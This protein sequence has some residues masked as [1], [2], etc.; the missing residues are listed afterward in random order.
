M[1]LNRPMNPPKPRS[2]YLLVFSFGLLLL[3]LTA[4]MALGMTRI[5]SF[6]SRLNE[7]T[8]SQSRN[9]GTVS[10]LFLSNGQRVSIIDRMF[11]AATPEERADVH[12]RYRRTIEIYNRAVTSL[13]E[14]PVSAASRAARDDAIRAAALARGVG[15]EIVQLLLKGQVAP[16]SELNLTQAVLTDGRLQETLYR[17][18]EANH[19]A[20]AQAV[21][22]ANQG[23]RNGF[24][25]IGAGGLFALLAGAVIAL[26]VI[27]VVAATEANLEH[28]KELAEVTLHSIVDGVITTDAS[29]RVDYLNPVA[30]R[31]LGWSTQDAHGKPL[32][33]VYRVID[34]R[35]GN[36]IDPLAG[37]ADAAAE[38]EPV[39]VRL[40]DRKGRE[41][42]IR[43]SHAP[44][45]GRDGTVHGMIVVFHDVSQVRAMA[46]QL[47]WQA[48]HDALTGLVNRREFER[49]LSE[50]IDTAK[51]Q[52][53]EHALLYLDL[54]N[55]K[56]VND[57][58]GHAAGDE[59]LRQLTSLMQTKMRGSDTLARLGGDEFGALLESCLTEQAVRVANAL[60]ETIREFRFVWQDK[61]FSVG[62]SIG[63][64]PLNAESRDANN[65]LTLADVCCYE[66]KNRGRDRV[67][68]YRP[69]DRDY[70][71]RHSDLQVVSQI[72]R[73]F[74]LG[75]FR[76][77]RQFIMPVNP[78]RGMP[79]HHE[80]LV[81]MLDRAGN[82]IPPT[83]FMP[84]AER[85]NLLT[86]IERWVVSTL[87]EYLHRQWLSGGI[88]RE[89][90][91]HGE[92]G[93]YSVNIS[94]ASINDKSFP[95]F[96]RNLLT[97]Y[98]LPHG[99]LCFEI[100]ETTAIS[101]LTKAAELMHELKGMGCRFALDDFGTGMSSFAY[102]KYLPVDY[103]KIAGMFIKDM[104][105]DPMDHAIVDSVNRIGHILGMQTVAES[106][107]DAA[108]LSRLKEMGVDY[109][110]G[111]FISEPEALGAES[112]HERAVLSA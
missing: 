69:Q 24:L 28:E 53:K 103:L 90:D 83:G 14:L 23:M 84:A 70:T 87:V 94:G 7:V 12:A 5:E 77:Y 31:Y 67:Q 25:L 54:D 38:D 78:A 52:G 89:T 58:C 93:F 104:E 62:V 81:R 63:L 73:A 112:G 17:L 40:V 30:E 21:A 55:F 44:I 39:S 66:A 34:E 79:P 107:E 13:R 2:Q 91:A 19:S 97:R 80:V 46:Q 96:L 98:T 106:V 105:T 60:R 74:E 82:L 75:Q 49:R 108:T 61:T 48:S 111:Y 85:Y 65:V 57:T 4:L 36:G 18:L 6:N 99:L 86:S 71:G 32:A 22:V 109:A 33:E 56:A 26:L 43:Y 10:E 110:Q 8:D 101:N 50:L 72:N 3:V 45:R 29:G 15:E 42:P 11:A 47:I 102:L 64:V 51:T 27:R 20:T 35:S 76:L 92:R 95:D 1:A 88:P 16:A 68:V 41:C 9:I 100:T 37:G 59:L